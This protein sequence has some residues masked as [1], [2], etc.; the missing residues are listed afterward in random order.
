MLVR[1]RRQSDVHINVADRCHPGVGRC[2]GYNRGRPIAHLLHHILPNDVLFGRSGGNTEQSSRRGIQVEYPSLPIDNGKRVLHVLHSKIASH[3]NQIQRLEPEERPIH[4]NTG[5]PECKRS[6]VKP[7]QIDDVQ[8][9]D[10]VGDPR[11]CG[12]HQNDDRL[13]A[14]RSARPCRIANEEERP[15]S[16]ERVGV[17]RVDNEQRSW[18][19]GQPDRPALGQVFVRDEPMCQGVCRYCDDNQNWFDREERNRSPGEVKLPP[20]HVDAQGEERCWNEY[21]AGIDEQIGDHHAFQAARGALH[22]VR[23]RPPCKSHHQPHEGNGRRVEVP[24][25][26]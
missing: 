12:T 2:L 20:S 5:E 18:C 21:N 6:W 15:G 7:A 10:H 24:S 8:D 3:R 17:D 25:P 19:E 26:P 9:K 4:T 13:A 22:C 16:K 23:G 1:H 14:E 11:N